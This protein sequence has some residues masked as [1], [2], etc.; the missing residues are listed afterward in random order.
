MCRSFEDSSTGQ[1]H[2]QQVVPT[3]LRFKILESIHSS[4]TAAH[5]GVTNSLEKLRA[6]FFWPGHK[7]DVS[8]FVS[9]CLV[10]QQRNSPKQKHRH[11]LVNRPPSFPFAH[12]GIDFL[13]P[14]PISNGNSYIALFG[15]HFTKWYEAVPLPDQTAEMTATA[16]L[17]HWISRF[18]VP[19]SIHT[20]QGR[21][22]ESKR[23]ESLI[24]SLQID[25]TRTTSFHPQSNAVIER[26]NRTLVNMLAKTIDDFQ[27]NWTQQLP[28]VMIAFRTSVHEST[29]YTPQFLVSGEEINL[30][31]DIQYPSPEQPNKTDVHQFVQ[32]KRVDMQRAHEAVRFHL[33]AA[34]QRRNALNNSKLHGPR[35]KPGDN[36]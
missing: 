29:G 7:K 32:Q 5:L 26:I 17:E 1:S 27:I 19:V 16:F 25:K 9:S 14:L 30:P 15:D 20:D 2:L 11:S 31:I 6:R 36:V 12:I 18:G 8:V 35:H 33:Q 24:H 4:T 23:F 21:N 10:C 28:Y 3:I 13:G 22:F 34:Q